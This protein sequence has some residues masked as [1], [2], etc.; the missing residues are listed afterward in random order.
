ML[1]SAWAASI[2]NDPDHGGTWKPAITVAQ[3]LQ[4]IQNLLD[5]PNNRD[6]A[7][8]AGLTLSRNKSTGQ[9]D[10]YELYKKDRRAYEEKV[11]AEAKKWPTA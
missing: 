11:R 6:P 8:V 10:A 5:E 1:T 3:I 9:W 4:G 7:Q 2:I